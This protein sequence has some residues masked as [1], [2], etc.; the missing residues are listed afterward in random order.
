MGGWVVL[1]G[2][3]F[4]EVLHPD[5]DGEEAG[6]HHDPRG[7]GKGAGGEEEV[8]DGV[9]LSEETA[10]GVDDSGFF[11]LHGGLELLQLGFGSGWVGGWVGG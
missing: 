6:V 8:E 2:L 10:A 4:A 1:P 3:P 5:G 11:S 9:P 7:K